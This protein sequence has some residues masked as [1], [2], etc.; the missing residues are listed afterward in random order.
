MTEQT[1]RCACISLYMK[2]LIVDLLGKNKKSNASA[3]RI[4][5]FTGKYIRKHFKTHREQELLAS[6]VNTAWDKSCDI[7]EFKNISVAT[8]CMEMF[9]SQYREL[10]E[11]ELLFN[12]KWFQHFYNATRDWSGLKVKI[13]SKQLAKDCLHIINK[14]IYIQYTVGNTN[15]T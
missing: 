13:D 10:L 8:L 3:D 14:E 11:D 9:D 6:I 4:C 15:G 2:A 7:G 12:T 1:L 5:K